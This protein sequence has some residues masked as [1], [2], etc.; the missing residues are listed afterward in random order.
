M[1][2]GHK[3]II[4][5]AD[6]A[7][8]FHVFLEHI[9]T[10]TFPLVALPALFLSVY[11][12]GDAKG[13]YW[14]LLLTP[15]AW[16][17]ADL[18]T[19]LVHWG[20]DTYGSEEFPVLGRAFIRPFREHHVDPKAMTRHS[21]TV[22]IG[23]TCIPATPLVAWIGW[24]VLFEE[25]SDSYRMVCFVSVLAIVGTVLTNQF[26]KWAHVDKPGFV[27]SALQ[28]L[29]IILGPVHHEVHHTKPHDTYYCITNGWMDEFLHRIHFW[30]ALEA[31]LS[32]IGI[33]PYNGIESER[34][35]PAAAIQ[36]RLNSGVRASK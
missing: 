19:G 9:A 29:R 10:Y 16:L 22:T 18:I 6:S 7:G 35:M 33:Q 27:I 17:L 25:P 32:W 4:H 11:Q 31:T 21:L 26:H 36:D 14:F 3:D 24:P 30:R 13:V 28:K 15:F 2:E 20:F 34:G 23:N 5:E 8:P 12:Y 1:A